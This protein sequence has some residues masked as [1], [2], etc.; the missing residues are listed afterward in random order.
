MGKPKQ[1]KQTGSKSP[2]VA[3]SPEFAA[4]EALA[5]QV[6]KVPKAELD[7]REKEAKSERPTTASK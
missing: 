6:V 4:F 5:K 1:D 3:P 2:P 7:R